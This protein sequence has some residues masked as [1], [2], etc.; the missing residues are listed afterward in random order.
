MVG[1]G[2]VPGCLAG[3]AAGLTA[4]RDYHASIL[5]VVV[6]PRHGADGQA[7]GCV[8][9]AVDE[10][11]KFNLV[12]DYDNQ[13]PVTQDVAFFQHVLSAYG[14]YA[15][16]VSIGNEQDLVQG[17][18]SETGSRYAAVWRLVEPLVARM[19]PGALKVAGEISP[20]GIHWLQRA[21][22]SGLPG[23]QAIAVHAYLS[24]YGFDLPSVRAWMRTIRLPL[25]VTEGLAGPNAWPAGYRHM[26]AIPRSA[27]RGVTVADA[28]LN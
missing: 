26:Y 17:T 24:H 21:W 20:W 18:K 6:D 10:G 23:A 15:W 19:S 16:A 4:L 9:A 2:N 27:M 7:L 28:W 14:R 25:W 1:V 3:S 22:A 11:Y 12:V 13:W 5:R 8:R